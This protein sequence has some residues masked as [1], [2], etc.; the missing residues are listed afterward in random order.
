[1]NTSRNPDPFAFLSSA[2]VLRMGLTPVTDQD[3]VEPFSQAEH[4]RFYRHKQAILSQRPDALLIDETAVQPLAEFSAALRQHLIQVH[5][6]PL[7]AG[8]NDVSETLPDNPL[9]LLRQMTYWIP[10]DICILQADVDDNYVLTC[11]SVLSPSL[12]NPAE[13]FLQPLSVIHQPIPEF[14][15]RL[16]PSVNRFFHHIKVETPVVRFNWS[17]QVGERLDR[18]PGAAARVE[19]DSPDTLLF[20]RSERQTLLRLPVSQAVVF[21]IRTHLCELSRLEELGGDKTTLQ[22]LINHI[23]SLSQ[24]ERDYKGL[25]GLQSALE[26]YRSVV[27]GH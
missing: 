16:L 11:A 27:S 14:E 21:L 22:K 12:W 13:K 7:A 9:A 8:K 19:D 10:D 23:Q 3:W 25:T 20:Y 26:R 18:W 17:I 24:A 6:Q 2:T 5:Q 1:M 4:E 15:A